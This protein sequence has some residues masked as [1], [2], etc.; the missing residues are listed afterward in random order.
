M[1][2]GMEQLEKAFEEKHPFVFLN[3]CEVG[4]QVPGLAGVGGFAESFI[5]LGASAVIAPLWSVKDD[6]AHEIAR[7]FYDRVGADSTQP[8]A[9]I[10]RSIRARA[11][12]PLVGEDTYAAYCFYGDPLSSAN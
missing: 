5:D 1:V 7:E 8:F 9:E 3:A 10:M 11:Y 12:D 4:R 6:L 2:L